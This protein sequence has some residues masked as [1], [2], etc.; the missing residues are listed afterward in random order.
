MSDPFQIK[1]SYAGVP[2]LQAFAQS[3]AYFRGICGPIGS[4]KSS[5]CVTELINRGRAQPRSTDGI[6]HSRWGIVRNTYQ[7]L[8]DTTIRTVHQW[9]PPQHF[10]KYVEQRHSYEIKAIPGC[11]IEFLFLALD[12][13]D[14]VKKLLSLELTGGWINEAREVPWSITEALMGRIGR[15]PAKR[16][17]GEFWYGLWADTNPPDTDSK[18]FAYFEEKKWL[19]DFN[20]MRAE[21]HLP[22]G[23]KPEEFV[24]IFH[25]PGG[26]TP[27]AENLHNLPGERRYYANISA[28]KSAEWIKVYVDGQY[29]FVMEGK[30]VY[31]EYNDAVHCKAV[32]PVEGVPIL[33]SF[34]FGLTPA[35]IFSQLLPDGRWLVFDEMTSDNMSVDEFGDEVIEHCNRAFRGHAQFIDVGDPAGDIRAETDKRTAFDILRAKD[36]DIRG[37]MTQDPTLRQE[38]VRKPL[39]TLVNGEP[40]FILHP[41]CRV[42]R[43]GF[44]GGYHRRRMQTAGPERYSEKPE[45][46]S[47]SHPHDAMQYGAVE[48]FGAALVSK[49]MDETDEF[50]DRGYASQFDE[51]ERDDT[52]GY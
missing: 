35:C 17:V 8:R 30:L 31:P 19:K 12:R 51:A 23:M 45:K 39:R 36:I 24:Q 40:Q 20:R 21:G 52:T 1:Y 32:E 29:G 48:H 27:D 4:G 28:G 7:Q 25:Q 2:T 50:F 16:D 43:K 10:G 15:F 26:M 47:F 18:W 14:D 22:I 9:L 13:P 37:A 42:L 38:A 5:A 6:R 46:N 34:D 11:N 49:V 44:M 3:D 41:R 33:R